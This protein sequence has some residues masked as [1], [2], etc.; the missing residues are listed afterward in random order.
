MLQLEDI[1]LSFGTKKIFNSLKLEVKQGELVM[2]LGKN[3]AG[4]S[5]LFKLLAGSITP[6]KGSII[7]DGKSIT[8]LL[9]HQR[10][11]FFST[12]AQDPNLGT[13][14][15]M[16]LLENLSFAYL[17]GQKRGLLP[18]AR[19]KRRE[20]FK[21]MLQMLDIGLENRLDSLAGELSGGQRQ[22]LSLIM[23]IL[24][25]AKALLLDEITAA[26][27]PEMSEFVM[28]LTAKIVKEQNLP[29]LMITH[30]LLHAKKYGDRI[31][32]LENGVIHEQNPESLPNL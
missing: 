21:T 7:V 20:Y 32:V 15:E 11:T 27:D 26:L 10:A 31:L 4:K 9:P 3:G 22:A 24:Q 30:N 1:E 13:F 25:E 12:V 19:K 16:S 29:A 6:Q 14:T 28:E 2:L 23:A 18:F 8:H 5:S 17:R